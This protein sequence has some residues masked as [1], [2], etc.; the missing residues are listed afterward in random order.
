MPNPLLAEFDPSLI[1][2]RACLKIPERDCVI[3]DQPR[4]V[5]DFRR[6]ETLATCCG[7]SPTQP[8]SFFRQALS[9][10]AVGVRNLPDL[11]GGLIGL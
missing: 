8:R 4:Q 1:S 5:L 11:F 6:I 2:L 7:W 9:E 10:M 3:R